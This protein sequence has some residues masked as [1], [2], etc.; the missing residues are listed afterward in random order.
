MAGSKRSGD[1][2][3]SER[4]NALNERLGRNPKPEERASKAS[5]NAALSMALRL[6]SEFVAAILVGSALGYGFDWLFGTSPWALIVMLMFG[7]AA[8][9]MNMVRSANKISASNGADTQN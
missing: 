7:F 3:F 5:N 9:V 8:G 2:Q 1:D 4:L 6:S